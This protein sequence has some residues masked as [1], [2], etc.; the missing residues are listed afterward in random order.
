MGAP[1][2][3]A[4]SLALSVATAA[5]AWAGGRLVEGLSADPR[6]RDRI[7]GAALA[8]P[9]LPPLAVGLMLLT[10]APVREISIPGLADPHPFEAVADAPVAA[11]TSVLMLDPR[12]IA[13]VVLTVAGLL[14][15]G[16]IGA[17][18]LR[19]LRLTRLIARLDDADAS[20]V[21]LVEAA[22][23]ALSTPAPSI[24]I[25]NATTEPLIAGFARP[26]LVLP[27]GFTAAAD[28]RVVHAVLAHELAHL[29]RGD[30]RV[31]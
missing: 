20:T 2:L 16:R 1:E 30:H 28:A 18:A 23:R 4:L 8:L 19:T 14:I 21:K 17:L 7:W 27:A 10:P 31:L 25:S 13:T 29:K 3:L 15:V 22:A 12:F 26:R 24:G 9:A 6:L 5:V 11:T